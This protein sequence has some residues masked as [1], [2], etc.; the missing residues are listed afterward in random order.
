MRKLVGWGTLVLA[1]GLIAGQGATG[2]GS[3]S[4]EG[5]SGDAGAGGDGR[6]SA[7][8]AGGDAPM[9][10]IDTGPS[11]A[12]LTCSSDLHEVLCD[13]MPKTT[14][15]SDQGCAGGMC[16]PA[17]QAAQADKSTVGC[18]YYSVNPDTTFAAGACFAAFVANTWTGPVT[19]SVDYGGMTL[20]AATFTRIPQGTGQSITY[21]PLT[22]G[23][24]QPGQIAIVFLARVRPRRGLQARLPRRH[25]AGHLQRRRGA[26]RHLDRHGVPHRHERAGRRL[27]HLPV[28]GRR[29]RHHQRDAPLAYDRVG[30]ELHRG[31]CRTR[32]LGSAANNPLL[33][34]VAS[35]DSTQ[36]TILP[37]A[38]I[39]ARHRRRRRRGEH[40]ATYT[41]STRVRCFTSIRATSSWGAPSR[42]RSPSACWGG[43]PAWR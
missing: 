1:G 15:P 22:N 42:R 26:A 19:I 17:C 11:C 13:G 10:N 27:R 24:L 3:S 40:A 23:Q 43:P 9:F 14:C 33:D 6:A 38:A 8:G 29:E 2:C 32:G 5:F 41:L 34:I 12:M 16:V 31:R 28:R 20:N 39:V 4:P 37:T 25:H 7:D 18:D 21:Q 36:V 35:V 30:H